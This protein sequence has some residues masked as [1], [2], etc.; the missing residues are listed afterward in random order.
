[1]AEVSLGSVCELFRRDEPPLLLHVVQEALHN[2]LS[3]GYES[4]VADKISSTK[5]SLV[6]CRRLAY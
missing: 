4:M 1:M 5:I 2:G 6:G 3:D